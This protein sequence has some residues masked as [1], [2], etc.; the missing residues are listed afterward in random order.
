MM[1]I[2]YHPQGPREQM[3]RIA[4]A[5]AAIFGYGAWMATHVRGDE[6]SRYGRPEACTVVI[7]GC[8]GVCVSSEGHILTA[9]HCKCERVEDVV[10]PD[11]R[12]VVANKVYDD[13]KA[14]GCV[15]FDCAG[16]GYPYVDVAT[17]FPQPRDKVFSWGYPVVQSPNG[18]SRPLSRGEGT[19]LRGEEFTDSETGDKFLVNL[20]SNH[21]GAPGWSGGPLF[22][23]QAQV[24][25]VCHGATAPM[26]PLMPKHSIFVGWSTIYES[27]SVAVKAP[28]EFTVYLSAGSC[29]PCKRFLRDCDS[30]DERTMTGVF[31]GHAFRAVYTTNSAP[32]FFCGG[33]EWL[34]GPNKWPGYPS[35][36]E[37]PRQQL[38]AFLATNNPTTPIP[39]RPRE[40][41]RNERREERPAM[42][43][44][45]AEPQGVCINGVCYPP[46]VQPPIDS[47][48]VEDFTD[49]RI[50]A[51][52]NFGVSTGLEMRKRFA[53]MS[54]D[55]L[56][57]YCREHG[58]QA[59]PYIL[60]R[61]LNPEGYDKFASVVGVS[62]KVAIVAL[63]PEREEMSGIVRSRIAL[64]VEQVVKQKIKDT[65]LVVL[66][67][68][69][70]VAEYRDAM[71]AL[72][73][74]APTDDEPGKP[75]EPIGTAAIAL[76]TERFKIVELLRYLF[77]KVTGRGKA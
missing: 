35:D 34:R 19:L 52:F 71:K 8:S 62:G 50:V 28:Q 13:G 67:E 41:A 12:R 20:L 10:W 27:Y 14:E 54:E 6:P 46:G 18:P 22:N 26:I 25:G 56:Q 43:P 33:V 60:S 30:Y 59:M 48:I 7:G 63:V 9:G 3:A 17:S 40:I 72:R 11:G 64:K 55:K 29:E 53:D 5:A 69:Q 31:A 70:D 76:V 24:I 73:Q 47:P 23:E 37:N 57:A 45:L 61:D 36:N 1:A 32:R 38:A 65:P 68:R 51:C 42:F 77:N 49:I 21:F 58:V 75:I 16:D 15:V 44:T 66:F 39:Q 74:F 2:G 4:L